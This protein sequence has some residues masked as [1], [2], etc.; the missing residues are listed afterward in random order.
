MGTTFSEQLS[1]WIW[2]GS[3]EATDIHR[4]SKSYTNRLAYS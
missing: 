2:Q 1:Q 3:T 4:F